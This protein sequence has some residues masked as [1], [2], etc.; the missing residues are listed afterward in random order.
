MRYYQGDTFC[1]KST[2]MCQLES[3]DIAAEHSLSIPND[4]TDIP[5][6]NFCLRDQGENNIT[7]SVDTISCYSCSSI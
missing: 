2:N 7:Y 4:E 3:N 1:S 5:A 6:D